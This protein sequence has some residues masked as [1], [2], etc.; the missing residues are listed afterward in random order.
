MGGREI[1]LP[2]PHR[3]ATVHN[4]NIAPSGAEVPKVGAQEHLA[5]IHLLSLLKMKI[6][7]CTPDLRAQNLQRWHPGIGLA[8]K[9]PGNSDAH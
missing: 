4:V 2:L 6:K 1:S 3:E 8:D 7:G 9:L 5:W